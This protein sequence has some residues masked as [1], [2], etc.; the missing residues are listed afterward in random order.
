M[1]CPL[2]Y[3]SRFGSIE[4]RGPPSPRTHDSAVA[5]GDK[6]DAYTGAAVHHPRLK[7]GING[8]TP[9]AYLSDA[10]FNIIRYL[11]EGA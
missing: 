5:E 3:D 2:R 10:K 4:R 1:D 11:R 6:S 8:A 7:S 9:F